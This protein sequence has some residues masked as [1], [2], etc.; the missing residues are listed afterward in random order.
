MEALND[1]GTVSYFGINTLATGIFRVWRGMGDPVAASQIAVILLL[2]VF[3]LL[4]LERWSRGGARYRRI[5]PRA[6][7]R[8]RATSCTAGIAVRRDRRL[9]AAGRCSASRCRPRCCCTGR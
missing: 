5:R 2:F 6:T 3:A 7:G 8:C 4:A 9:R 1:F